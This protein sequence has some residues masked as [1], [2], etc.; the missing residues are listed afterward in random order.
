MCGDCSF[1][2]FKFSFVPRS[3]RDVLFEHYIANGTKTGVS[4][5]HLEDCFRKIYD[6]LPGTPLI[7]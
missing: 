1:C 4:K 2:I 6:A 5:K 3:I 7:L